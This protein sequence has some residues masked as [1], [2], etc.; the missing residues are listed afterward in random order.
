MRHILKLMIKGFH[1]SD[2]ADKVASIISA[3]F[4]PLAIPTYTA[5]A[6]L[7]GGNTVWSMFLPTGSILII[8]LYVFL[9]TA[10]LP[11]LAMPLFKALKLIDD[12]TLGKTKDRIIPMLFVA[13]C[14]MSA[15]FVF[16]DIIG[17]LLSRLFFLG[18]SI[19]VIL[20]T[21]ISY[22]WKISTH[23]AALGTSAALFTVISGSGYG[24]MTGWVFAAV[25]AAGISG[26]ARIRLGQHDIAQVSC[27]FLI[28]FA[29]MMLSLAF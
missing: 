28:G 4:H 9:F 14:Y 23:T 21:I 26:S 18:P 27:G 12:Y 25:I 22:R 10:L 1:N 16:S 13:I 29:V 5:M 7:L 19:A 11:F 17:A 2:K 3:I 20:L 6:V 15:M 8:V 24:E